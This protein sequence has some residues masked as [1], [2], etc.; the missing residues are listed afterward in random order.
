[1]P[2]SKCANVVRLLSH[3]SQQL[4]EHLDAGK[5][6]SSWCRRITTISNLVAHV[7]ITPRSRC[8]PVT[9]VPRPDIERIHPRQAIKERL[10]NSTCRGRDELVARPFISRA[11]RP[12]RQSRACAF[13]RMQRGNREQQEIRRL[14]TP[15]FRENARGFSISTYSSAARR[16]PT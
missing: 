12:S 9:T 15:Y 3:G 13:H 16:R 11:D 5:D 14:D 2:R 8:G 10:V 7:L 6:S 4:F 1:M